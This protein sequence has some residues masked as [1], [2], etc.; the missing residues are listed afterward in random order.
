MFHAA[1]GLLAGTA[2]FFTAKLLNLCDIRNSTAPTAALYFA[3]LLS[4]LL[5]SK[6]ATTAR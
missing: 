1:I 5:R 2:A 4:K 6:L 3:G